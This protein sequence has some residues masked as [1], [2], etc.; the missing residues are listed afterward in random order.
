MT[1]TVEQLRV[2][3]QDK[4]IPYMLEDSDY[5]VFLAL[6]SNAYRAASKAARAIAAQ[7]A[8][9]VDLTAGPVKLSL[10]QKFDHYMALAADFDQ[11]ARE[12]GGWGDGGGAIGTGVVVTGIS[13]AEID[14]AND[15]P[16]R[17]DS[18]FYRGLDSSDPT[19][20]G[21]LA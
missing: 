18:V 19:N 7:F 15:D 16:D 6:E 14:A 17:Y 8:K 13:L 20:S 5:D 1:I 2:L 9:K 10:T 12:G 3:V 11:S 4:T 21:E